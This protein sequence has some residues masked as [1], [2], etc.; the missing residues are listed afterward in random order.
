M[1]KL[2]LVHCH[3]CQSIGLYH[4]IWICDGCRGKRPISREFNEMSEKEKVLHIERLM[5]K[6]YPQVQ[7]LTYLADILDVWDYWVPYLIT[8]LRYLEEK[9]ENF[10]S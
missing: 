3:I 7:E 2:N 5:E 9:N 4:A 1:T 8:R 10:R 6:S